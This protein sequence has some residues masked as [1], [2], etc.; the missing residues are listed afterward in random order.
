MF[1]QN[2]PN[3]PKIEENYLKPPNPGAEKPADLK[4]EAIL[5]KI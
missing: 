3:V 4:D 5:H 1:S 2:G